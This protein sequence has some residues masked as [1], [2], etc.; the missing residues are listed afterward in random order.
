MLDKEEQTID[1]KLVAII[2]TI[3]PTS[4]SRLKEV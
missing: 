2:S 1:M 4:K 3:K